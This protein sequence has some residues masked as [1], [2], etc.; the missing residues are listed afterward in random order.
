MLLT[1]VTIQFFRNFV[2]PQ[3][4]AI[5]EDLTVVVGKN[6]SGKTTILK[7][8]H[9]LNPAN[10]ENA[11]FELRTDYPRWRLAPDRRRNRQILDLEPVSAEFRLDDPT[12]PTSPACSPPPRLSGRSAGPPAPTATPPASRSAPGSD[13][14]SSSSPG[15]PVSATPSAT[16]CSPR[17]P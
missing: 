11:A 1:S 5:E 17:R 6:E 13:S 10:A 15:R 16:A 3:T 14:S 2:E 8:L 4:I 12:A 9:R 7:A